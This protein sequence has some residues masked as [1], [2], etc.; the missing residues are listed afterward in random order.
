MTS[1]LLATSLSDS[2]GKNYAFKLNSLYLNLDIKS[3]SLW[4]HISEADPQSA[5]KAGD[6]PQV[7][8]LYKAFKAPGKEVRSRELFHSDQL[9]KT[10]W[11]SVEVSVLVKEWFSMH[12]KSDLSLDVVIKGAISL[13]VSGVDGEAAFLVVDTEE[14]KQLNR[15]RRNANLQVNDEFRR[16]LNCSRRSFQIDFDQVRDFQFIL[17]PRR[18]NMYSCAGNC[19]SLAFYEHIIRAKILRHVDKAFGGKSGDKHTCCRPNK[20]GPYKFVCLLQTGSIIVK[21]LPDIRVLSCSCFV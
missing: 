13:E 1:L 5:V 3:A 20:L 7:L 10:G 12:T 14:K 6:D 17:Y 21:A 2:A 8:N 9:N 18:I 15:K 11:Y 4:F 19:E 16:T